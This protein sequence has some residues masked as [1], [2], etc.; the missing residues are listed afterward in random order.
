M[1]KDLL[2][3]AMRQ[4]W[5]AAHALNE[6]I[7]DVSRDIQLLERAPVGQPLSNVKRLCELLGTKPGVVLTTDAV[8]TALDKLRSRLLALKLEASGSQARAEE[9]AAK[10]APY[11][12]AKLQ[13]VDA[14]LV[15]DIFVE[16]KK[17]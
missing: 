6:V 15:G 17:F 12:H 16:I 8:A 4:A 14:K 3:D 13:N 10:V 7:K 9:L 5:D 1:P 2:L 11:E